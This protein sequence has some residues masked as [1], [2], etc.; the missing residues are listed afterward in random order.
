[1]H[2]F[3]IKEKSCSTSQKM[4]KTEVGKGKFEVE[5]KIESRKE[6]TKEPLGDRRYKAVFKGIGKT[7]Q[8]IVCRAADKSE[9]RAEQ[10]GVQVAHLNSPASFPFPLP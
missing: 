8:Q 4:V 1:M 3:Q 2:A 10:K 6:Q 7:R 5:Q 9:E